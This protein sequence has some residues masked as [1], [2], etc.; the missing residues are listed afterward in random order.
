MM[1]QCSESAYKTVAGDASSPF[2][3]EAP[4]TVYA[5][6]FGNIPAYFLK[7]S[8]VNVPRELQ[9]EL[10]LEVAI[11]QSYVFRDGSTGSPCFA[12]RRTRKA[13]SL[14]SRRQPSPPLG[15]AYGRWKTAK[16]G[17]AMA[18]R[19]GRRGSWL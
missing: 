8:T 2:T 13:R 1:I 15:Q 14:P 7:K 9:V 10:G 5:K 3:F 19:C 18:Q 17:L 11:G 4:R 16:G 12:R 6:G